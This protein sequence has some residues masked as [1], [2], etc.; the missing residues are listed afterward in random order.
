MDDLSQSQKDFLTG[1]NTR[2]HLISTMI[3][4]IVEA[5]LHNEKFSILLVDIDHFKK[6]N[7]KY[8]HLWG[9]E[10]LKYVAS[11]LRLSLEDKGLIFRYGGDEFVVIFSTQDPKHAFYLSKQFNAVMKN[12]PFLFERRLFRI[13]VSC[14]LATYPDDAQRAEKLL[15][16]ADEALYFSKKFGRNTTTR[17]GRISFQKFKIFFVIFLEVLFFA[18]FVFFLSTYVI[19]Y[20]LKHTLHRLFIKRFLPVGYEADT[21]IILKSGDVIKGHII[22]EDE[23]K[24][25]VSIFLGQGSCTMN[26]ERSLIYSIERKHRK[27]EKGK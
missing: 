18:T 22:T 25:I 1:F 3:R 11:T 17:A 21:T 6:I 16:K 7:D 20:P 9:D 27:E 8:G 13:T 15:Q 2:E 10:F 14:G 23:H 24:L 12:R 19:K 26:I 4:R 5:K